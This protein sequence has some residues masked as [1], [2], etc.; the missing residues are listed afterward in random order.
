MDRVLLDGGKVPRS[1][2]VKAPPLKAL[3][4]TEEGTPDCSSTGCTS[5]SGAAVGDI[6]LVTDGKSG[7][8]ITVTNRV[9]GTPKYKMPAR[10]KW[11]FTL[12]EDTGAPQ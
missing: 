8:T 11:D 4:Q 7:Y 6:K 10:Q 12:D 3:F 2:C 9:H 1:A 5:F